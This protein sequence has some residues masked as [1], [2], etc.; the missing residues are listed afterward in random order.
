ME[1]LGTLI[2]FCGKMAAGKST[3]AVKVSSEENA[4]LISEDEW[5]ATLFPNKIQSFEEY[6][7]LSAR[8]KPLIKKHVQDILKSGTSVVMD[9]PANTKSQRLWFRTIYAEIKAPYQLIYLKMSDAA[10]LEQLA[11]RRITNPERAAFD[12]EEV[13]KQI[14]RFFE[15][16]EDEEGFEISLFSKA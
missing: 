12:N 9:F 2:F 7:V 4:V 15:E 11:K 3:K 13:F 1:H 6:L 5:L 10:C 16:P 14:T 8:I